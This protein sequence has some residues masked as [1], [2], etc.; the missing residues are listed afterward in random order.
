MDLQ[1]LHNTAHLA[2]ITLNPEQEDALIQDLSNIFSLFNTLEQAA[3]SHLSP[4]A[5]PLEHHQLLRE[6]LVDSRDMHPS[7]AQNAPAYEAG[8]ITVP[9]VIK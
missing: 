6:D 7:L 3:L 5:H 8:F 4:L 2:R 1:T 9:T